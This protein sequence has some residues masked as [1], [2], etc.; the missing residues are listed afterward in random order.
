MAAPLAD[1]ELDALL[2]PLLHDPRGVVLAVSGGPDSTAL[3]GALA[4]REGVRVATVDHGLRPSA[5]AEADEVARQAEALGLP[6]RILAWDGPKPR[7][8]L[9][10]AA[11]AARYRLLA[12]FARAVGASHVVTAH[13]RD[14]QAETVLLRLAAGSGVAGLAA[15]RGLSDLDGLVLARP[16]L[17]VPKARLVA[18]CRA[19]G[20]AFVEDPA[21]ADPRFARA[22]LRAAR[23]ALAAEGLTDARLA[24]L[25]QRAARADDALEAAAAEASGRLWDA[26]A[27][28]GPGLLVLPEAVA[29]RVVARALAAAVP[30]PPPR[31][32]RLERLVLA[33]LLPALAAGQAIRR[34]L[35]GALVSAARGRV[36]FAPA[37]PRR[38]PG[39]PP[40]R[41]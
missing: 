22:R 4:G 29:L 9:Q 19:R 21:N 28:D 5:R 41:P 10:A 14:D 12:E 7:A 34:S 2:S 15:M 31:L 35:A 3:M 27:L 25:A 33:E 32:E 1:D 26:G 23:A 24:T 39:D 36:A 8:G 11:R 6:H 40:S 20:W 13:T 37:P 17:D 16:F 18:T 38:G 30:G